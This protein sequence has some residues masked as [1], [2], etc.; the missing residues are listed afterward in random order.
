MEKRSGTDPRALGFLAIMIML[1]GLLVSMADKYAGVGPIIFMGGLIVVLSAIAAV[2]GTYYYGTHKP[3]SR[4]RN[5]SPTETPRNR[6]HARRRHQASPNT[7]Q[8]DSGPGLR[9][10]HNDRNT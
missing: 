4:R 6:D 1:A 3:R 8:P 9:T 10:S 7:P 5:A 2:G